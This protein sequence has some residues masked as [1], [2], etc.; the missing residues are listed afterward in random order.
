MHYPVMTE[1]QI[2]A[3]WKISLKTLLKRTRYAAGNPILKAPLEAGIVSTME[4]RGDDGT[5]F[6]SRP[7]TAA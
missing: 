4:D 5:I 2:A 1:K 7:P 6:K 3:R